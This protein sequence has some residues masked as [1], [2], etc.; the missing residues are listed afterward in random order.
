MTQL[1]NDYKGDLRIVWK[2]NPLPFHP[3]A[4]PAATLA[5]FAYEKG[6]DKAFWAAHKALFE[7]QKNLEDNGLEEISKKLNLPWDKIKGRSPRTSTEPA[8]RAAPISAP[9]TGRA[10]LRPSS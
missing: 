9:S 6:G 10:V 4:K 7:G 3:R 1:M 5:R 8:S 2:D